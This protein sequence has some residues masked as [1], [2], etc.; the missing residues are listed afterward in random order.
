MATPQDHFDASRKFQAYYDETLRKVGMRAPEPV[1]GQTCNDYRRETL[2]NLKRTF[3][4]QNHSL[5]RVNYRGLE[6]DA[7]KVFEPQLLQAAVQ[8]AFN[9][10]NVP[11]GQ[12]REIITRD[13]RNGQEI[14]Q[15]IG[16]HS[17]VRDMTIPGRR[18]RIWDDHSK[19]WFPPSSRRVA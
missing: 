2:R 17:F 16:Q 6:A 14:H 7:L 18:A 13:E 9:P 3:L 10:A 5:Y 19:S 11:E 1:L 4:P 15:F 12:L 8:E